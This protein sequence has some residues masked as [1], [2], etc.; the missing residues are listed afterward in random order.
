METMVTAA[1]A[2]VGVV[3]CLLPFVSWWAERKEG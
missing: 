2:L 1:I 3:F